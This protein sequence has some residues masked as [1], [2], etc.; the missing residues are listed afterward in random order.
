VDEKEIRRQLSTP[1][2]QSDIEWRVQR[3]G[4]KNDRPWAM[5]LAYV[6]NRA[7]QKRL[8]DVF[9]VFGWKNEYKDIGNGGVE[10]GISVKHGDEWITKWDAATETNIEST[11]GGR[12]DAMKRSAVQWGIGRYLYKLDATFATCQADG[13]LDHKAKAK[14]GGSDKWF[15]WSAPAM[16]G[17]AIPKE[18]EK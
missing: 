10:C 18:I 1:F 11:K 13:K 8:D 4:W 17:W 7:I 3:A 12:S 2:K 16:P 6:T 15:S 14:D 9:G 5:V